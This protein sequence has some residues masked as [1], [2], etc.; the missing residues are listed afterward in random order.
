[1]EIGE[2]T[3]LILLSGGYCVSG[4]QNFISGG[5]SAERIG[6][7]KWGAGEGL[8]WGKGR[9][10]WIYEDGNDGVVKWSGAGEVSWRLGS[11]TCRGGGG[12]WGKDRI[13]ANAT[14][15]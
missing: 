1:M 4:S 8:S 6:M 3:E 11:W 12:S 13:F 9:F 14:G 10:E 15:R 2:R 7:Q 5:K